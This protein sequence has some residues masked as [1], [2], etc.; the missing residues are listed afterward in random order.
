MHIRRSADPDNIEVRQRNEL[1]PVAD[2]RSMRE[3]FATKF[4]RAFV[5]RIRDADNLDF[6][7]LFERRQMAG[8]N[9]IARAHNPDPQFVIILLRHGSIATS[10]LQNHSPLTRDK[11]DRPDTCAF[12]TTTNGHE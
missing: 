12:N 6:G 8:A 3:M 5:G 11:F 1:R 4:F 7:M 2:W 9:N 10:I